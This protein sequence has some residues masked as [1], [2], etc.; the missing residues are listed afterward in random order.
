M[1]SKLLLQSVI[2]KYHLNGIVESVKWEIANGDLKINFISPTREM[3]GHL[4]CPKFP[5]PDSSVGISNTTQLDKLISITNGDLF[6]DYHKQNK[7]ITKLNISDNQFNL[8]YSLADIF[9]IPKSGE[10]N[11]KEDYDLEVKLDTEIISALIKAKNA[12]P[13]SE[14]VVISPDLIGLGF[15]FG[16]DVEYANKVSYFIQ[17]PIIHNNVDFKLT[18]NSS[19]IKEILSCNKNMNHGSL[20]LQKDGLIKF[21]FEYETFN[22]T[23]YIVAQA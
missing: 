22:V 3:I 17:N 9:T 8:S 14:Y 20:F 21:H 7:V 19:L 15:T 5:L 12:L 13:S 11:G 1:I 18:Y 23:Y 10:F 4:T 16:G 2:E 6:L